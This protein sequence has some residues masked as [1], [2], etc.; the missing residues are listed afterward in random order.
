MQ[1]HPHSTPPSLARFGLVALGLLALAL[2]VGLASGLRSPAQDVQH[3]WKLARQAGAYHYTSRLEQTIY[4]AARLHAVGQT[5]QVNTLYLEGSLDVPARRMDLMLWGEGGSVAD[6]QTGIEVRIEGDQAYGRIPGEAW[7]PVED[8]SQLFAPGQDLMAYLVDA[9]EVHAL[10]Q[11]L[12]RPE[13]R[14][15]GFRVHGP[16]FAALM[17]QQMEDQLRREGRLPVGLRLGTADELAKT[18]G[19]GELWVSPEGLPVR[20]V[21]HLDLAPTA[22]GEPVSAQITTDFYNFVPRMTPGSAVGAA[23]HSLG[24]PT[25]PTFWQ[26]ASLQLAVLVLVA[27][28]MVFLVYAVASRRQQAFAAA[29]VIT[30]L[31]V[32]PLLQAPR[33][34][35]FAAELAD[36]YAAQTAEREHQ[37]ELARVNDAHDQPA[38]NPD[39]PA[40]AQ[41]HPSRPL[42]T[43]TGGANL[44][45]LLADDDGR[46]D[47]GDGLTNAEE[48]LLYGT[49]P[50]NP[51]TDGDGLEDGVEVRFLGTDP[52]KDDTDGDGITDNVEVEGVRSA[53]GG[54]LW[55]LN[56]LH[57][58][59]NRDGLPDG[60]ECP[61]LLRPSLTERSP[62]TGFCV[63]T[64]RDGTP[65]IFDPDND[66]D[67]VD[68]QVDLSPYRMLDGRS[69][70]ALTFEDIAK[71]RD[72]LID[73]QLR[74]TRDTN[75]T[76]A[77]N[78]LDW[79]GGDSA[80]QVVRTRE[81]TFASVANGAGQGTTLDDPRLAYGDLRLVPML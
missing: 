44:A 3:A 74:P 47:D 11:H 59:S 41:L 48:T 42:V 66:G 19:T 35:A 80:G 69:E 63:D 21:L 33:V 72:I 73:F 26:T 56:P 13:L 36:E 20:L 39:L 58:D 15:Y 7:Q 8:V 10:E 60:I 25:A 62:A 4:P 1:G 29:L 18:T 54:R 75:L 65:D 2:V 9:R 51:D 32:T 16:A 53:P 46:D 14:G 17:R 28:V 49:D 12:A 31:V 76:Y 55:Y 79:P 40:S 61:A 77:L 34:N 64:D 22:Q 43:F 30:C 45:S 27:G 24:L 68:D 81:T 5:P 23:L 78:V 37:A 50:N 67:K 6:R 71:D 70:L 57:P 52:L 38:W